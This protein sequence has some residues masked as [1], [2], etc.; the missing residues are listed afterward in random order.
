[1][2]SLYLILSLWCDNN[3]SNLF[4]ALSSCLLCAMYLDIIIRKIKIFSTHLTWFWNFFFWKKFNQN[5]LP[6]PPMA[7]C[8]CMSVGAKWSIFCSSQKL[9]FTLIIREKKNR[10]KI[11]FY[12]SNKVYRP[13]SSFFLVDP[14]KKTTLTHIHIITHTIFVQWKV[15]FRPNKNFWWIVYLIFFLFLLTQ[16]E[17]CTINIVGFWLAKL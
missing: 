13:I 3:E 2:M 6:Q 10:Q 5:F 12:K 14:Q 1:M 16:Y 9:V 7:L 8:Y 17:T 11:V 4:F 15:V